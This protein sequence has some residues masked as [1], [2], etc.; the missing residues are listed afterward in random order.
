MEFNWLFVN[1]VPLLVPKRNF[2]RQME[3]EMWLDLAQVVKGLGLST[4]TV[5]PQTKPEQLSYIQ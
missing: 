1:D 4:V 2:M 3:I 5:I